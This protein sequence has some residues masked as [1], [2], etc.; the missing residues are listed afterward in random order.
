[1]KLGLRSLIVSTVLI[2]GA[3]SGKTTGTNAAVADTANM[4][5]ASPAV[6]AAS[7][8]NAVHY[9]DW[10]KAAVPP[11]PNATIG[12]M[13]NTGLYQ[14]QSTDEPATVYDWYKSR[15]NASW[16]QDSTDGTRST[17]VDGVQIAVSKISGPTGDAAS[18]K[19]MI[20]LTRR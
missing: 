20:T 6:T 12:F 18:A 17:T 2:L 3:C 11:Y 19:T 14:F 7:A 8:E 16:A 9:P 5:A 10:A 1:M 13:V 15:V 4:A